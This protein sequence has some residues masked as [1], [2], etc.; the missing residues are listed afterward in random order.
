M[1]KSS[2]DIKVGMLWMLYMRL[3]YVLIYVTLL[4]F[5]AQCCYFHLQSEFYY[6]I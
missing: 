2:V 5:L 3:Y 4:V 6:K 1:F